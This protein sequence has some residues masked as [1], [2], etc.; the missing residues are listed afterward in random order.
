MSRVLVL[1]CG[2]LLPAGL[3][4]AV[5]KCIGPQGQHSYQD[6]PCPADHVA[7]TLHGGSFSLVTREPYQL[8]ALQDSRQQTARQAGTL[9][10]EQAKAQQLRQRQLVQQRKHCSR[11]HNRH[12]T[13]QRQLSRS[14]SALQ[15]QRLQSRLASL[16]KDLHDA[17]CPS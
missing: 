13:L 2:L 8:R 12:H 5:F 15:T 4:A 14:R 3:A 9:Q 10:Q 7:H 11:L 1:L 16:S 17:A 6:H